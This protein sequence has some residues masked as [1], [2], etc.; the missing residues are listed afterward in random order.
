MKIQVTHTHTKFLKKKNT[1]GRLT[2]TNFKTDYKAIG[3]KR[4]C[5]YHKAWH[6]DQWT[7]IQNPKIKSLA[8]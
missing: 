5:Y 1:V 2:I 3:I 7:R 4:M 8:N 6:V